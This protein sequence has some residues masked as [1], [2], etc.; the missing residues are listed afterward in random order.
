MADANKL[1]KQIQELQMS[2]GKPLIQMGDAL[3]AAM[4]SV[5]PVSLISMDR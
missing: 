2:L 5:E 3:E 4:A 1:I